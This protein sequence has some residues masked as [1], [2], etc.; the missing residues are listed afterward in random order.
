MK[1]YFFTQFKKDLIKVMPQGN[2]HLLFYGVVMFFSVLIMLF[3]TSCSGVDGTNGNRKNTEQLEP[4]EYVQ[5]LQDVDNGIK[6]EKTIDD[7]TFSIQYKPSEYIACIEE[8]KDQISDSILN[9][10]NEE[11]SDM[12]YYDLTISLTEGQGELL[13]HD[14]TSVAEYDARVQYFAFDMQQD[15]KLIEDGDTI[16]CS[17]YHFERTYDVAPYSK[18]LLGF[19]KGKNAEPGERILTFYDKVFDKGLIKFTYTNEDLNNIPKLKTHDEL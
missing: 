18:F 13:K 16:P 6:K 15:I 10:K 19:V 5:W 14:L 9:E 4:K 1:M 8:K 2:M 17:L 12:E 11:L 3:I 7:I